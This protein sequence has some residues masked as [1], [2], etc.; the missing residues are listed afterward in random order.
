M[1]SPAIFFHF[2]QHS[3]F[4]G[5]SNFINKCQKEI[6]RCAPPSSRV[7]DFIHFFRILI[8]GVVIEVKGQKI[9]QNYKKFCPS[10]SISQEPHIIWLSFMVHI[11]KMIISLGVFLVGF[12][13]FDF[14]G[15]QEGWKGKKMPKMTNFLSVTSYISGTIYHMI[16]IYG[17]HVCIKG[18]YLWAFFIFSKGI[19]GQKWPKMTKNL[20]ASLCISETI[21]L[22]VIFGAQNDDIPS[23]YFHFFK[24]L[25]FW[26]FSEGVKGQKY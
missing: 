11:C 2:F 16:F 20:S 1:I 25:I 9:V 4:S 22:I 3:D 18:W 13:N 10:C 6:L 23:N 7:C 12:Q 14:L 17:T 15:C 24:I 19:K 26:V 21:H 5:F 8:C